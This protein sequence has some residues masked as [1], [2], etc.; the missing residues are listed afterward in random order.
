MF[1]K[2]ECPST[3][4]IGCEVSLGLMRRQKEVLMCALRPFYFDPL[5]DWVSSRD[6]KFSLSF[7]K[8]LSLGNMIMTLDVT[9]VHDLT[10]YTKFDSC[11]IQNYMAKDVK[12]VAR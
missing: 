5:V 12:E 8:L 1:L 3:S 7:L 2:C 4:R 9:Y 11:V 10:S 6:V